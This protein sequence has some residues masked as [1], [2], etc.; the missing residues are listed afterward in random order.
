MQSTGQ[1]T[2]LPARRSW[3][4]TALCASLAS[5][6]GDAFDAS[7]CSVEPV[8]VESPAVV[9]ATATEL[10]RW[11]SAS[12]QP[13]EG[14]V[15]DTAVYW[16]E[17]SG[18]IWRFVKGEGAAELLRPAPEPAIWIQGFVVGAERLYWGQAALSEGIEAVVAP[19]G[20]LF[21]LDKTGGDAT[22]LLEHDAEVV[23]PAGVN[24]AGIIVTLGGREGAFSQASLASGE[25][26]EL[27][28]IPSGARLVGDLF[29]WVEP[30]DDSETSTLW[31]AR[32]NE[33]PERVGIIEGFV[34]DV[35]P[36]YVLSRRGR[37]ESGPPAVLYENFVLLDERSRCR[38]M[39][40]AGESILYR[41]ALDSEHVYWQSY[42]AVGSVEVYADGRLSPPQP[43]LPLYRLNVRSGRVEEI[44]SPGFVAPD[45]SFILGQ[46]AESLYVATPEALV[47]IPKP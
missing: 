29:Y 31:R 47:A 16:Y 21:A 15:D 24:E 46:D 23:V 22:L 30:S 7:E 9:E 36:D 18:A 2:S 42:N 27:T 40:A 1:R 45:L 28:G 37:Y 32:L 20:R 3:L 43:D 34:F 39:P 33:P 5:C 35:G 17:D 19:P 14:I 12:A 44:V 25:L 41:A 13:L 8:R 11:P 4:A 10:W 6:T 26:S 38:S